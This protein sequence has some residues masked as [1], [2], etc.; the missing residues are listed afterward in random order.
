[1]EYVGIRAKF[2]PNAGIT[3]TASWAKSAW[4]DNARFHVVMI[5]NVPRINNVRLATASIPLHAPAIPT[6]KMG[7][8]ATM[9]DAYDY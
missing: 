5:R 7:S 1:V 8:R 2:H 6:V 3:P 9:E 4:T